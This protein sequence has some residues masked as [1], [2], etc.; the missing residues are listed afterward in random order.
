MHQPIWKKQRSAIWKFLFHPVPYSWEGAIFQ[1]TALALFFWWIRVTPPPGFAVAALAIGAT[2]MAV[3]GTR[4]T[5]T[6][7]IIW[8][9]IA[10]CFFI[11]EIRA[12]TQDREQRDAYEA[13]TRTNE[14]NH[15]E[16]ILTTNQKQFL[17]TIEELTT[18]VNTL[19]GGE[20][21][22][23]LATM[24]PAQP[25]LAFVHIGKFPL[26]GV[27]A[28][29]VELDR[30]GKNIQG[31]LTG[32]TVPVG[33]MIKGHANILP[34]P[35]GLAIPP[36]HFNANIFFTARN[37]DWMELLREQKTNGEWRRA[38]RVVGRFTSLTKERTICESIDPKFPKKPNGDIDDDFR[39]GSNARRCP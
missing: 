4:F 28:R 36:D 10:F 17:A 37:G 5:R 12:I 8:I 25:A 11:I 7:E 20:S 3:R 13:E 24:N 15:F 29:I 33:D 9:V 27:A 23:Y 16:K 32:I 22:C 30:E 19:T 18:N 14:N 26:Y 31:N 21:A 35:S 34:W 38:M 2:V 6:E 1:I 39:A